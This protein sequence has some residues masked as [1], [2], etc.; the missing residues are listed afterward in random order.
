MTSP[1]SLDRGDYLRAP[2]LLPNMP[3][4]HT[5][6]APKVAAARAKLQGDG[7]AIRGLSTAS[8]HSTVNCRGGFTNNGH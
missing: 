2:G 6:P 5:C 1:K 3:N 8:T 4:S 7:R